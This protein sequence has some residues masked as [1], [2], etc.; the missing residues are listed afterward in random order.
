MNEAQLFFLWLGISL[1]AF[2]GFIA[3]VI[4]PIL[5]SEIV[6]QHSGRNETE[7]EDECNS[8]ALSFLGLGFCCIMGGTQ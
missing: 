5:E 8:V 3:Y 2:A 4:S 1:V 6:R 7:V